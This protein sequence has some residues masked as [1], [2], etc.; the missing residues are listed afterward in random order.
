MASEA[1]VSL[2]HAAI[3]PGKRLTIAQEVKLQLARDYPPGALGWV[4][5]LSWSGPT[6]VPLDQIDRSPGGSDT[7]WAD[8]EKDKRKI[9]EF[10]TRLRAGVKKP[11]VVVRTPGTR[12]LRAVDGHTRV[13]ASMAIGQPVTAWVGTASTAHGD[14]ENTHSRQ[15]NPPA[16]DMA[17]DAVAVDLSANTARLAETP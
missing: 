4:D 14:W 7:N 10:A 12:L 16:K 1:P 11:I 5:Q 2:V 9:A 8:A 6:R 13:L 3:V 17:G 15:A